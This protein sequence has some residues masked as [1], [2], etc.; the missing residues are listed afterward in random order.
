MKYNQHATLPNLQVLYRL[1]D[2]LLQEQDYSAARDSV[3]EVCQYIHHNCLLK[4]AGM[5][6]V[7]LSD[8]EEA[9]RA[10]KVCIFFFFLDSIRH[11]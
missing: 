11:E 5:A 4:R 2:I 6:A 10:F 7:G 9:D 3:Y 8:W 1:S